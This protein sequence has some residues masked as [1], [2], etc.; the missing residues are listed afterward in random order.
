MHVNEDVRDSTLASQMYDC[1]RPLILVLTFGSRKVT[2]YC[3]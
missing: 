3:S 1:M 2:A